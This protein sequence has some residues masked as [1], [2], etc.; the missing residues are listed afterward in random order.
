MFRLQ[1]EVPLLAKRTEPKKNMILFLTAQTWVNT[2]LHLQ[3][4]LLSVQLLADMLTLAQE[5]LLWAVLLAS[6]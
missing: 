5:A 2:L 3:A 6:M 4:A 1:Q